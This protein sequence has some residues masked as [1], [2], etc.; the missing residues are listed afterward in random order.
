[1]PSLNTITGEQY[2]TTYEAATPVRLAV[3]SADDFHAC[4][5]RAIVNK[6]NT[7][8]GAVNTGMGGTAAGKPGEGPNASTM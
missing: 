5:D 4:T 3:M 1:M 7:V 6:S 8:G 2:F